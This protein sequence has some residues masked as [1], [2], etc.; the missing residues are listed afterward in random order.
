MFQAWPSSLVVDQ[1]KLDYDSLKIITELNVMKV[2]SLSSL[3][4]SPLY[5]F[6]WK[7]P[8]SFLKV[9]I[10]CENFYKPPTPRAIK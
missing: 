7:T 2:S 10:L 5:F 1:S 9:Q 6:P 4:E 3:S 8:K